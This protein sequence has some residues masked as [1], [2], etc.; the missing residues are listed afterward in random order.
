MEERKPK[1]EI[2]TCCGNCIYLRKCFGDTYCTNPDGLVGTITK[3]DSCEYFTERKTNLVNNKIR[4]E[5][6]KELIKALELIKETCESVSSKECDNMREFGNCPICEI[7]GDCTQKEV[8]EDWIIS[9][10]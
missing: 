5:N 3:F 2:V 1:N 10:K 6:R 9:E 7:L 4:E 8:P